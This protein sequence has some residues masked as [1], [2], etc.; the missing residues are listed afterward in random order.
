MLLI[1]ELRHYTFWEVILALAFLFAMP[2]RVYLPTSFIIELVVVILLVIV[3]RRSVVE[4][5]QD[6]MFGHLAFLLIL[7]ALG[8]L[9]GTTNPPFFSENYR[10]F[11][12]FLFF[13][14]LKISKVN[15][16][17]LLR[18]CFYCCVFCAVF[19]IYELVYLNFLNRGAF[20]D[21]PIIGQ[22][23]QSL[24]SDEESNY[25]EPQWF[26]GIP[27]F[28]PVGFF[29]QP[30]K[31]GFIYVIG[32]ICAYLI[33]RDKKDRRKL[34]FW[35]V[36][37]TVVVIVSA[38]K[39]AVVSQLMILAIVAFN[40]YPRKRFTLKEIGRIFIVLIPFLLYVVSKLFE[41]DHVEESGIILGD[42]LSFFNYPFFNW[43]IGIGIPDEAD[44]V[45]HGFICECYFARLLAQVGLLSFFLETF[46]GFSLIR[47]KSKKFNWI[48]IALLFGLFS[49]YCVINAYFMT[50][51]LAVIICYAQSIS[52]QE[53]E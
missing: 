12:F 45:A 22:A 11:T 37:F 20:Y 19:F 48:L 32:T 5:R 17:N 24:F 41:D 3:P 7:L 9:L 29:I 39:T 50:F 10:Y 44:L 1:R 6:S 47:S 38:A 49:H 42:L 51:S 46:W 31:S 27:Y 25:L 18:L 4:V 36:F 40:L 43:I 15:Y 34:L 16:D 8:I 30:Q 23:T 33:Y 21:I 13:T 52:K 26:A 14:A 53:L 2:M 28:R 35:F